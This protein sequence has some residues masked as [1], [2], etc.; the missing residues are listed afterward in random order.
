[1]I[2]NRNVYKIEEEKNKKGDQTCIL[3]EK[4]NS[5][6]IFFFLKTELDRN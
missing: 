5:K 2:G 1:M 4:D 6:L 3:K